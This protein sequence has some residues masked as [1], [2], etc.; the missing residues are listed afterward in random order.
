MK[1][2]ATVELEQLRQQIRSGETKILNIKKALEAARGAQRRLLPDAPPD[3]PQFELSAHYA[4]SVEIGGDLFNFIPAGGAA[5]GIVVGDVTGHGID[6]A[7]MMASAMKSF[8]L[9]GAARRDP[10]GVLREVN[11]DLLRDLQKGKF[12]SAFYCVLDPEKGS[13]RCARAGHCPALLL[14]PPTAGKREAFGEVRELTGKGPALGIVNETMFAK[15][16]EEYETDFP[17][18]ATLLLYT[19]GVTEAMN[20]AGEEFAVPRLKNV[21]TQLPG[22]P[23]PMV[24][25][26]ILDAV[27]DFS[28]GV[29]AEDDLTLVAIRRLF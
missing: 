11:G 10:A 8:A 21:L 19:D 27:N 25:E 7:L 2:E 13:L 16:L 5:W 6:A 18:G 4:P 15:A 22:R 17:P 28:G 9:R 3:I 14:T 20:A 26:K 1:A 12:V 29:A 23:A 24:V